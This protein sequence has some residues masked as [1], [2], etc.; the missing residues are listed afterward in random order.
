MRITVTLYRA[1]P[2]HLI[3]QRIVV[4][5]KNK[6]KKF[7]RKCRRQQTYCDNLQILLQ[8]RQDNPI[9]EVAFNELIENLK[10]RNTIWSNMNENSD[11]NH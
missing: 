4:L 1:V 8:G 5:L 7:V 3:L 6:Y 10:E 11:R 9:H 2:R